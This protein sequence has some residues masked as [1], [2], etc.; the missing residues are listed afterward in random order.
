MKTIN[1]ILGSISLLLTATLC[2]S[3]AEDAG[4]TWNQ[5]CVRCHG[6]DGKGQTKMG[7]KLRIKDLTAATTKVRLTEKR[8]VETITEGK[9]DA[10]GNERMPSFREKIPED[11]RRALAGFVRSLVESASLT[12]SE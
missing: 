3:R 10:S 1:V 8:I 12:N 11:Q 6:Q 5:Y 4:E 2:E 9:Q 7:K